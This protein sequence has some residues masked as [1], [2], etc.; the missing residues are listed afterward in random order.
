MPSAAHLDTSR[1][2]RKY[3]RLQLRSGGTM[4]RKRS[5]PVY[6]TA[7]GRRRSAARAARSRRPGHRHRGR[8][9][10]GRHRRRGRERFGRPRERR[11]HHRGRAAR[12][13]AGAAG[14]D[15]GECDPAR[16]SFP[17]SSTCTAISIS[18]QDVMRKLLPVAL[19]LGR[20]DPPHDRQRQAGNHARV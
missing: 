15:G 12:A 3:T 4:R 13:R 2:N 7:A 20:D 6:G 17:A 9:A 8:A 16:P 11:P 14:R 5:N 10:R 18:P 1:P 19:Q